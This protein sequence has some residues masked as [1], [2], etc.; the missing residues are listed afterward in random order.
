[1]PQSEW[2]RVVEHVAALARAAH[3]D[4]ER[5]LVSSQGLGSLWDWELLEL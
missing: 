5:L 4:T 1:M 3:N 2:R